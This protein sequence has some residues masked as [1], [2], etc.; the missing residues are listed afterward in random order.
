MYTIVIE[1]EC[2]CFLKSD[3][4]NNMEFE[5]RED[6]IN[7]AR[8]IECLMNQNFCMTH[9]FQAIDYND[10]IIIRS[11]V[12]PTYD[13]D[14]DV[15]TASELVS[16]SGVVIGFDAGEKPPKDAGGN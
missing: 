4:K 15:E 8:V 6:M 10:K 1:N 3:I 11:T 13:E 9:Y 16:R 2:A 12:R 7:K 14:E 5:T